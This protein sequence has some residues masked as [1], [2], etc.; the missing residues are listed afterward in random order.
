[1]FV[2]ESDRE[3][4]REVLKMKGSLIDVILHSF[5]FSV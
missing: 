4:Q 2:E 3:R 5:F 1:M